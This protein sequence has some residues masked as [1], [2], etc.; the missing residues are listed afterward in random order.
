MKVSSYIII[1]IILGI[2]AVTVVFFYIFTKKLVKK[3]V[4]F[5]LPVSNVSQN[6]ITNKNEKTE[7]QSWI[8]TKPAPYKDHQIEGYASTTSVSPQ[9]V[10]SFFVNT[11]S[12]TFTADVYR[13]GYYQGK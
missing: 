4:I 11:K 3:H 10:I 2:L 8:L 1:F 12:S 6:P 13:M 5:S 7:M 9:D